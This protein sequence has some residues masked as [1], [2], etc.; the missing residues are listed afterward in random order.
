MKRMLEEYGF[1]ITTIIA[2]TILVAVAIII[3]KVYFT[4]AK[5]SVNAEFE[6]EVDGY[7]AGG[8]G[9]VDGEDAKKTGEGYKV[10]DS[11]KDG[12]TLKTPDVMW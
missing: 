3:Y 10:P 6:T 4:E 11:N 7:Q 8:Q 5:Q 2:I 1:A 9:L 12:D